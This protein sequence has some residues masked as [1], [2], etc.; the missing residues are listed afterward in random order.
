MPECFVDKE[1][2]SY[3]NDKSPES[4]QVSRLSSAKADGLVNDLS[5]IIRSEAAVIKTSKYTYSGF[6]EHILRHEEKKASFSQA[7][8]LD[9]V[10]DTYQNCSIKNTTREA[11]GIGG[12]VNFNEDDQMPETTKMNEFFQSSASKTKLIGIIQKHVTNHIFW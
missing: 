5:V 12:T 4:T 10:S 9:I 3:H 11:R 6:A 8:R 7:Q 2:G 1:G